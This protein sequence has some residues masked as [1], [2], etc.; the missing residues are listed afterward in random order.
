MKNIKKSK[1]CQS[2]GHENRSNARH[3]AKCGSNIKS[4][5]LAGSTIAIII[6]SFFLFLSF[7]ENNSV[8]NEN[9]KLTDDL[10]IAKKEISDLANK[11]TYVNQNYNQVKKNLDKCSKDLNELVSDYNNY[12][13]FFNEKIVDY[14]IALKEIVDLHESKLCDNKILDL[15]FDLT[16]SSG[17]PSYHYIYDNSNCNNHTLVYSKILSKSKIDD[18]MA[19][20]ISKNTKGVTKFFVD[21]NY[22]IFVGLH[23]NNLTTDYNGEIFRFGD[24]TNYLY[25]YKDA[26]VLYFRQSITDHRIGYIYDINYDSVNYFK[27]GKYIG[28]HGQYKDIDVIF[29]KNYT[30][31]K[32]NNTIDGIYSR[33]FS[34]IPETS[35]HG[36]DATIIP[37]IL[38]S[39][40][41]GGS[42]T[43]SDRITD[44]LYL[45]VYNQDHSDKDL[46]YFLEN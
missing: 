2:C 4:K 30:D 17:F 25:L 35:G 45:K 38:R 10:E 43:K 37:G 29:I 14:N 1:I 16:I 12:I 42:E 5:K 8:G 44:L 32:H 28:D 26:N 13:N 36:I 22:T 40:E 11:S 9:T 27:I 20:T 3:C 33:N 24:D 15:N 31:P 34:A 41:F 6:L 19:L 18:K 23:F 46:D 39:V 7:V 21:S